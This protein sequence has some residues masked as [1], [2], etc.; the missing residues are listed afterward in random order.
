[1]VEECSGR[2][3]SCWGIEVRELQSTV[4]AACDSERKERVKSPLVVIDLENTGSQL[5]FK[6][7]RDTN[8][9][10]RETVSMARLP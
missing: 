2:R 10:D 6:D 3:K 8:V 5:I 4:A 1:V 7:L 9:G